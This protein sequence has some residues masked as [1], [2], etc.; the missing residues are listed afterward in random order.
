MK[1]YCLLFIVLGCLFGPITAGAIDSN[2]VDACANPWSLWK[3]SKVF[4]E[5]ID[6]DS[7]HVMV[8][9]RFRRNC[10]GK[11]EIEYGEFYAN[12]NCQCLDFRFHAL[13]AKAKA[14]VAGLLVPQDSTYRTRLKGS[15]N[16]WYY[17][18]VE[19]S[20]LIDLGWGNEISSYDPTWNDDP[21]Y[22]KMKK[23]VPCDE[24][25]CI[26]DITPVPMPNG[27]F[28]LHQNIVYSGDCAGS[29]PPLVDGKFVYYVNGISHH[30]ICQTELPPGGMICEIICTNEVLEEGPNEGLGVN[31][32]AGD[33]GIKAYPSPFGSELT[34]GMVVKDGHGRGLLE[35]KT[36]SGQTVAS[37]EV[38]LVP[39]YQTIQVS[40]LEHLPKGTF[41]LTLETKAG[42]Y[43]TTVIK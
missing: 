34:I 37:R 13:I 6:L 18:W 7:C 32:G 9:Y 1:K 24:S 39:G 27:H 3:T 10:Q 42:T 8:N 20:L 35:I 22:Y 30:V 19:K 25:C 41:L 4:S 31:T 2:C 14:S 15:C 23:L 11:L 38:T 40:G 43:R 17:I 26:A 28:Q 36:T 29:A 5:K 33:W 21:V 16:T 12:G